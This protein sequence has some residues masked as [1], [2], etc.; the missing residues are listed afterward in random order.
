MTSV[1]PNIYI[2]VEKADALA[3]PTDVLVLKY[4]QAL[5][6]A[7]RAAVSR[8]ENEGMKVEAKL[9]PPGGHRLLSTGGTLEARSV[10]FL[11][12]PPLHSFDYQGLREFGQRALE[13]LA[14]TAPETRHVSLTLH[15]PGYGLDESE[16]LRAEV[17]G[18]MDAI[19]SRDY[20][21]ALERITIVERSGGRAQRLSR[22][23]STLLEVRRDAPGQAE[24]S[25]EMGT[26]ARDEIES[27]GRGSKNK[28]HVFVAMPFAADFDDLFHYGIQGAVNSAGYLCER[29]DLASFT[30]DVI[31]WV[32]DR[33]ETAALLVADL[34]TANPNVYLEV[35][36]AWGKGVRTVLVAKDPGDLKFDVRGQRC[37][38]YKNIQHLEDMLRK[39][40]LAL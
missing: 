25:V 20:P 36:Y 5:Y 34:S 7:D 3:F 4:A 11:G 14:G 28:A 39:E 18:L 38:L 2:A 17:A 15:G 10:L 22:L 13:V 24:F 35:G 26:I 29:A 33:I 32:K 21:E 9:P 12:V 37:L 8:L 23:L 1:K 30:G 31:T 27:A 40:L 6:G 19:A 16:A